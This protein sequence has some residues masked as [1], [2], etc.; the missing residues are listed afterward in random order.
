[1]NKAGEE[2]R[3]RVLSEGALLLVAIIWGTGFVASQF[4][5]DARLSPYAIMLGRFAVGFVAIGVVFGPRIAKKIKPTDWVHG[6]AVGIFLFLAFL[7][8]IIGLQYSTPANNAF[9]TA[10]N[11]VMVPFLEWGATKRKPS[12]VVLLSSVISLLGVAILSADFSSGIRFGIGDLL[13][14]GSAFLFACQIVATEK[15]T[16][17]MDADVLVFVQFAYAT[18]LSFVTFM[19]FDGKWAA[20]ASTKGAGALLYLGLFSTCL[21]YFLQTK[22]QN[23]V[24]SGK[25]AI[26][27]SSEALFGTFFSILL[28]YDTASIRIG[29]GGVLVVFAVILAQITPQKQLGISKKE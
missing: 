18:V 13:T 22:A 5:L 11:V 26:L 27:L 15:A 9:I 24:P 19:M 10:T 14:L 3:I 7:L 6:G 12:A 23:K 1:M 8:Q 2:K 20:F 29:L 28:G 16:R 4:A 17:K 21:C 25:A